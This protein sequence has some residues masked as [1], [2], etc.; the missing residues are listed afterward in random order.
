M[1]ASGGA[2]SGGYGRLL[3]PAHGAGNN[4]R[5][6]RFGALPPTRHGPRR[7]GAGELIAQGS[8]IPR[9]PP[10]CRCSLSSASD[11]TA[12]A[13]AT[14]FPDRRTAAL[15]RDK[16]CD[17]VRP[18]TAEPHSTSAAEIPVSMADCN[19]ATRSDSPLTV[20][21]N[22]VRSPGKG[23]V[24][25]G[26]TPDQEPPRAFP[27]SPQGRAS[28]PT[29]AARRRKDDQPGTVGVEAECLGRPVQRDRIE[30]CK[31]ADDRGT[32]RESENLV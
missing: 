17:R 12:R 24:A 8:K 14:A 10:I 18:I 7:L 4:C 6:A 2:V 22:S 20:M 5:T 30:H 1:S 9:R 32:K 28:H 27:R 21:R 3:S 26:Q 31:Q 25:D 13:S 19:S 16:R 11:C 15:A 23:D 29:E